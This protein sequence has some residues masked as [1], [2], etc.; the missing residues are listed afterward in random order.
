MT[1]LPTA[2]DILNRFYEAETIYMAAPEHERDFDSGMGLTL[3]TDL[4]LHQSPDLP[5][6]QT[7]YQGHAGFQKWSEEM[8]A[9]F[10]SLVVSDPK[11]FEREG[12]DEVVVT[13][14]LKLRTREGGKRWEAP[15]S[16]IVRVDREKGVITMLRPIYWDVKGLNALLGK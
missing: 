1:S 9:L 5:Y 14:V 8:A 7:L 12:D 2:A 16:Q 15:L 4:Q 3:S 11:V 10:D 6:T 13:S